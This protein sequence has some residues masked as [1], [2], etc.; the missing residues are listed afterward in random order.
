MKIIH[1]FTTAVLLFTVFGSS[2][3]AEDRAFFWRAGSDTAT[4]YL[5][6]SIHYADRSFYPLRSSIEDAFDRAGHLVVEIDVDAVGAKQYQNLLSEKGMYAGDETIRDHLSSETWQ[7]LQ[8]QL[9]R[10]GM[11]IQLVEKQKPGVMV[12]T[13]TALQ[14]MKMGYFPEMGI[15]RYF[16]K[17]A[18]PH[19]DVISLETI[20]QQLDVFLDIQDGD[21][22]LQE[23]LYSLDE[24]DSMMMDM[25][26]FWKRGDE[27]GLQKLLFDDALREYPEFTR[28]YD[29]LFYRRNERMVEK[30]QQFLNGQGSYF[31]VVGAGH[32]VG[33][34]GII[35]TLKQAGYAVERL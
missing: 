8:Q 29:R 31:V 16:L 32:L 3:A 33:D 18:G 4:V 9:F 23:A 12:L 20:E 7:Q 28:I 22:L 15:D 21:L 14:V 5:L 24:A 26:R 13:L 35:N 6:G 2:N 11:P 27:R 19:K 30:I 34:K 10:L 25:V 1:S 17:Q